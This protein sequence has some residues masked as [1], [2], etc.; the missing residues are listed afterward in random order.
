M[1]ADAHMNAGFPRSQHCKAGP[2]RPRNVLEP[3]YFWTAQTS[4]GL[5]KS[6]RPW[7]QKKQNAVSSW[8]DHSRSSC[9]A[10]PS[11]MGV[12]QGVATA[13][14]LA[15]HSFAVI[16]RHIHPSLSQCER[17]KKFVALMKLNLRLTLIKNKHMV[18]AHAS[19]STLAGPICANVWSD[20]TSFGWLHLGPSRPRP[21]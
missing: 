11:A 1:K 15:T 16:K 9:G 19:R 6:G 18:E 5:D 8:T 12:I 4:R 13:A 21:N 17:R 20:E 10:Q 3:K 7:D 2:R 14:A